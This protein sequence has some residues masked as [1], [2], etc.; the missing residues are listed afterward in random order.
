MH[1]NLAHEKNT[2]ECQQRGKQ[3]L[4]TYQE[5]VKLNGLPLV[6]KKLKDKKICE[7]NRAA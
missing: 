1:G 4:C 2:Q 3:Q 7:R 6:Q 5:N